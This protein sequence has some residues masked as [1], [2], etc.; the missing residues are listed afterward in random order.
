MQQ[1]SDK[2]SLKTSY[3]GVVITIITNN[4]TNAHLCSVKSNKTITKTELLTCRK[5]Q[6]PRDPFSGLPVLCW[7][8][9]LPVFAWLHIILTFSIPSLIVCVSPFHK[10]PSFFLALSLPIINS[11]HASFCW[12]TFI[13]KPQHLIVWKFS[14]T[15]FYFIR[16]IL[17]HRC[18]DAF[19]I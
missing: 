14:E 19:Q 18:C 5:T 13:C 2:Q 16:F 4:T 10:S 15:T 3:C 11:R 12:L 17:Q 8:K 7:R 6:Q 1:T 9:T